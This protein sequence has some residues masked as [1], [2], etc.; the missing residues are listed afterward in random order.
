MPDKKRSEKPD[1]Y[2]LR[3][4]PES[5]LFRVHGFS[6]APPPSPTSSRRRAAWP[7]VMSSRPISRAGPP[8]VYCPPRSTTCRWT[9]ARRWPASTTGR[10]TTSASIM[11][12]SLVRCRTKYLFAPECSG[13]RPFLVGEAGVACLF[14][15]R[16]LVTS[17]P[18]W[19]RQRTSLFLCKLT[20]I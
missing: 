8:R 20:T 3:T 15:T 6:M 18:G 12:A 7:R 10:V 4:L 13:A 14:D 19:F 5:W 2:D 17:H 9:W 16:F 1:D 11:R